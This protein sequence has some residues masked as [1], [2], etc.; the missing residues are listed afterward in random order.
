M[1]VS[2]QQPASQP[3]T[4]SVLG[5]VLGYVCVCVCVSVLLHKN[6]ETDALSSLS[7]P[8]RE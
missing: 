3:A 5:C 6:G 7:P 8:S 2:C 4:Q 1:A